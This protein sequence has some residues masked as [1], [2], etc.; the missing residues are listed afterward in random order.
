M[1]PIVTGIPINN[2]MDGIFSKMM[3]SNINPLNY[4]KVSNVDNCTTSQATR[5]I[6]LRGNFQTYGTVANIL[7]DFKKHLIIPTNYSLRGRNKTTGW[8]IQTVWNVYGFNEINKN[9]NESW[10]DLGK[11]TGVDDNFYGLTGSATTFSVDNPKHLAFRYIKFVTLNSTSNK[12][13]VFSTSGIEMFGAF[14]INSMYCFQ[15]IRRRSTI[16]T[17]LLPVIIVISR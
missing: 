8:N 13:L 6:I 3:N 2:T 10:T 1:H 7:F 12:Y 11:R 16:Y 15:S 4:V 17:S 5:N 9:N 14:V